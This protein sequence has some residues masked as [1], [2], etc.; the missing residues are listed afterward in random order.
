[1][2]RRGTGTDRE[3]VRKQN[4]QMTPECSNEVT[5]GGSV[6]DRC[7][8]PANILAV[9]L[10]NV[11]QIKAAETEQKHKHVYGSQQKTTDRH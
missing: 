6:C 7:R 11:V 3:P 1:M 8:A 4:M 5:F 10:I 2:I 9:Q